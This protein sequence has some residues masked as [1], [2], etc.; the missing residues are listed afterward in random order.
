MVNKNISI[1]KLFILPMILKHTPNQIAHQKQN[2]LRILQNKVPQ[3]RISTII[4]FVNCH[5][6]RFL[7]PRCFI[8]DPLGDNI[9]YRCSSNYRK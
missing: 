5:L 9:L 4:T 1:R 6:P 3:K 2:H 7:L 8:H